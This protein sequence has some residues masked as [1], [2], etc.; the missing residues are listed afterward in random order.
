M[1][2]ISLLADPRKRNLVPERVAEARG[3]LGAGE[4]RWLCEGVAAEFEVEDVPRLFADLRDE[5]SNSGFDL[6]ALPA[7]G[8]RKKMLL[9]DM[10][11]TIIG[12][13]CIDELAEIAGVGAAVAEITARAMNGEIDFEKSLRSRV[14]LLA[15][16]DA[17]II[18]QVWKHRIVINP[19]A[20]ELVETMRA[21]GAFTAIVSGGFTDF[22]GRVAAALGFSEHRANVLRVEKGRISGSVEEPI[23]GRDAK[24]IYLAA[25]ADR[26]GATPDQSIA[27]GDG[28]NDLEM[29]GMAGIGVAYRAKPAVASRC[30]VRIDHCDLTGLLYLQ[31]YSRS[32]FA[33]PGFPRG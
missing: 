33:K 6:N 19:G 5:L 17:R 24:A 22:T 3:L 13:E 15:G 20:P 11:S 2:I 28:A 16:L 30:G 32:E 21:N 25:A 18:E 1:H 8:R 27:V 7:E 23:L 10:D 31:G 26:I 4:A 9:A 29:L 14:G 12:Q